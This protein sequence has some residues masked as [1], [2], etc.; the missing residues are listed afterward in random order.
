[1]RPPPI[2]EQWMLLRGNERFLVVSEWPQ[3][4]GDPAEESVELSPLRPVLP[5]F[6]HIA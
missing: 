2:G 1:M 4:F 5:Q 3:I 6:I